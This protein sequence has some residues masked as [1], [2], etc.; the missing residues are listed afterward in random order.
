MERQA[1]RERESMERQTE[2]KSRRERSRNKESYL[3]FRLE[4]NLDLNR[5]YTFGDYLTTVSGQNLRKTLLT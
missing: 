4:C 2:G 5:Q 1:E 3:L